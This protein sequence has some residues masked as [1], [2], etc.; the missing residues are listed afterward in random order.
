MRRRSVAASLLLIT[1]VLA[2]CET[3]PKKFIRKKPKPAHTAA[4]VYLEEGNFQKKYSNEYYYKSHYTLWKT[5]HGDILNNLNGNSKKLSRSAQEAYSH[6]EQM[7]RYLKPEKQ[8]ELMP[9]VNELHGFM[10]K[11]DNG[12]YSKSDVGSMTTDL[13]RIK[14]LVANDY[15]YDKIKEDLLPDSV[16]LGEDNAAK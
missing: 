2:G 8:S 13:S 4:V 7:S 6:L 1:M 16:D 12:S 5:F 14:R 15:Y 3:L 9:L 11:F 10:E